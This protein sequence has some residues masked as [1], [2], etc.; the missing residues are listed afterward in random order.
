[1][2][3]LSALGWLS[4]FTLSWMIV[5]GFLPCDVLSLGFG[6]FFL[7]VGVGAYAIGLPSIKC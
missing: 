6:A 3:W 1:M 7:S 4:V 5:C 2:K